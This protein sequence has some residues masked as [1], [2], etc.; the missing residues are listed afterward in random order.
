MG[1]GH[2]RGVCL[3]GALAPTM[4]VDTLLPVFPALT[5]WISCS[6]LASTFGFMC[7]VR[8]A[9]LASLGS[10]SLQRRRRNR[11][12]SRSGCWEFS[13]CSTSCIR[14]RTSRSARKASNSCRNG[15][16]MGVC[17]GFTIISLLTMV[18]LN[19][20]RTA[21]FRSETLRS[22]HNRAPIARIC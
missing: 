10:S 21:F 20:P 5:H 3:V 1:N 14:D 2:S 15:A 13:C 18:V 7:T 11:S 12:N 8:T 19:W 9:Y 4:A 16:S 17:G 22:R 6:G